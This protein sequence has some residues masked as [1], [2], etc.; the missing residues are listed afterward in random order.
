MDGKQSWGFIVGE[1]LSARMPFL[2]FW[3]SQLDSSIGSTKSERVA[4]HE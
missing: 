3:H 1:L 2:T 4:A